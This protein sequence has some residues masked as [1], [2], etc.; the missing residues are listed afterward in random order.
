[1]KN[2]FILLLQ[3]VLMLFA[4]YTFCR[5]LFY[6]F[7]FSYFSDLSFT[8]VLKLFFFGLRFDAVAIVISN[9]LF[10]ALHFYPFSL[11]YH[12]IYQNILRV[13]FLFVNTIAVILNL[14]DIAF[15]R[16]EGKRA[17]SDAIRV[18]G[19]GDDFVN[20]VPRMILDYWYL[21]ALLIVLVY[22]LN[23]L[24][25]KIKITTTAPGTGLLLSSVQGQIIL[26]C[27]AFGLT[28][29]GFR[30]G[31][32]YRP[33]NI[34]TASRYASG[35]ETSLLLNTPFTIIKTLGKN[36]LEPIRYFSDE[37]AA[38]ISPVI[39]YPD[40]NKVFRPLNV[41]IIIVESLGKEY[42]GLLNHKEGFTPFLD[43]LIT[44]SIVFPN[45]FAN[46]K[47]SIEGIPCIIA[48]IPALMDEPFITSAYNGN[49]ISS[50]ANALKKKGYQNLFFHGGS[51]G[52][53]GF[54]N[55]SKLAG[56]DSYFGR[57]EYNN[58]E[59][60]DGNWG[61]FDEPFLQY[62]VQKLNETKEPF[63]AT[64]FTLS[65]HHPYQVPEKYKDKF[66]KGSLPIHES[67]AY[68]DYSL[69]KFFESASKTSWYD[70]TLFVITGDHTA[71]SETPF[72]QTRVGMYALPV[73]FFQ[74]T[75]AISVIKNETTSQ[76]DITPG[77]LDYLHYDEPFFSFG[78]SMFDSLGEHT[79]VSYLNSTYQLIS[80][81]CA[82]VMDTAN[83][84][85]LYQFST[86]SL[87]NHNLKDSLPELQSIMVRK[88][89]A[90]IQQYNTALMNNKMSAE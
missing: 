8:A 17:T 55:F 41:I 10:I 86:D 24:Y 88:L 67:I 54:D 51:N 84:H 83:V 31:I 5:I 52:T 35:K 4:L 81:D 34:M 60:F 66:R 77:V 7:N 73:I 75:D 22:V 37:E 69:M 57:K 43:S 58:D 33:I 29:I 82:L 89:K 15:V 12:K 6:I 20:T 49:K 65:S 21:L 56:Y 18:M 14:I 39:H 16:F 23:K 79:S 32:Q 36:A 74:P 76:I 9:L 1:M 47:R 68:T 70:S 90:M 63:E 13:L 2:R 19:F 3:R 26:A 38:R 80:G 53:M 87:L 48:G 40:S 78:T 85:S 64:V 61:I 71:I 59:D 27:I 28:F 62:T 42:M 25:S 72:Y 30:G 44:K 46:G 45:A 11:F 50:I